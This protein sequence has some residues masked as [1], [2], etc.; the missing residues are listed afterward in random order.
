M[1]FWVKTWMEEKRKTSLLM[2]PQKKEYALFALF[3]CKVIFL[4]TFLVLVVVTIS[5]DFGLLKVCKW[6]IILIA[7]IYESLLISYMFSIVYHQ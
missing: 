5:T 4:N 1:N 7:K 3:S 6:K 2:I